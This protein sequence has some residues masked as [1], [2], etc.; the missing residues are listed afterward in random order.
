MKRHGS[1][2]EFSNGEKKNSNAVEVPEL[3]MAVLTEHDG[4]FATPKGLPPVRGHEHAI[5][6]LPGYGPLS[7]RPYR[8]P[9]AQKEETEKMVKEMLETVVIRPSRSPFSSPAL[10]VKKKDKSWCFCVDY[11]ALNRATV[12]DKFPIPLMD[13]LL[14]ELYGAYIFSKLDLR[15]SYHSIIKYV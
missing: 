11:C 1:L 4:T 9:H 2:R 6:L 7:V 3:I 5:S 13:Q 8:H 10:L 12:S 14:D 15:S